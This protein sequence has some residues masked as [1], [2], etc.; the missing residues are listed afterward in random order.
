MIVIL[1]EDL[2]MN[3]K[4]IK[5]LVKKALV[6]IAASLAIISL[7][8][9]GG[10]TETKMEYPSISIDQDVE[11]GDDNKVNTIDETIKPPESKEEETTKLPEII[12]D[13]KDMAKAEEKFNSE[14]GKNAIKLNS[15][16]EVF[17]YI[18]KK[19]NQYQEREKI[20]WNIMV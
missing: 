15:E 17:A 11:T 1:L 9:C 18:E 10:K 8:A 12:P 2:Q 5:K 14:F 3:Y 16:E 19:W 7:F 6:L 4:L 20:F 13:K